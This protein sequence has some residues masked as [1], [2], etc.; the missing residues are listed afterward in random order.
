MDIKVDKV[1][2]SIGQMCPM[3]IAFLAKTVRKMEV[4]QVLEVQ[5][6]DDGAHADIP[7]WCEQ[8][9]NEFLGEENAGDFFKYFVKKTG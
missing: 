1:Q 2:N 8:T 5:A 4:G 7:A 3:P 9:G 6:D